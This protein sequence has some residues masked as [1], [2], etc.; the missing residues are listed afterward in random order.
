MKNSRSAAAGIFVVT[1][2]SGCKTREDVSDPAEQF[3]DGEIERLG[4]LYFD[5]FSIKQTFFYEHY[6]LLFNILLD[7]LKERRYTERNAGVSKEEIYVSRFQRSASVAAALLQ[8]CRGAH[9]CIS[10]K[11]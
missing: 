10:K 4:G 2:L 9:L 8:I 3:V 7:M 5:K 6:L 1:V 11:I